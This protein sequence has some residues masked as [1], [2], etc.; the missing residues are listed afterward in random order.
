MARKI[1]NLTYHCNDVEGSRRSEVPN[2]GELTCLSH[3]LWIEAGFVSGLVEG[4]FVN[5][6]A[7]VPRTGTVTKNIQL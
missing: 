5:A 4:C 1:V 3:L 6:P 2:N 7:K